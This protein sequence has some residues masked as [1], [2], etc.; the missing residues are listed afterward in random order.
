MYAARL[1]SF[2]QAQTPDV[3]CC[4]MESILINVIIYLAKTGIQIFGGIFIEYFM[5]SMKSLN[6]NCLMFICMIVS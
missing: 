4:R 3:R 6:S 1:S 5:N 2:S